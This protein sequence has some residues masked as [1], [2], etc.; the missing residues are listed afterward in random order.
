M[1]IPN[2]IKIGGFNYH[3]ERMNGPFVSDGNALDGEHNFANKTI[4]VAT[5][6]CGDYQDMVFLHEVCHAII[7]HYC[8]EEQDEKF[9]EQFSKGLY[10][11]LTDNPG[12][13]IND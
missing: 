2:N 7:D 3:V 8:A 12:V 4:R 1:N 13:V 10:Q 11:V 9:V 5:N 6:G